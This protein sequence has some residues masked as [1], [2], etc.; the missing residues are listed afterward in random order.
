[1]GSPTTTRMIWSATTVYGRTIT[2]TSGRSYVTG[3]AAF[4]ALN[5]DVSQL[6][7]AGAA[8]IALSGPTDPPG[9]PLLNRPSPGEGTNVGQLYFDQGLQRL[10]SWNGDRWVDPATGFPP[11]LG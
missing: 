9:Q 7:A 1:M 6:V 5:A 4:D 10:I 11:L 8:S 2:T 3:V